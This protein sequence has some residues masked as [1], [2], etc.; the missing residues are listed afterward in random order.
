M[1]RERTTDASTPARAA[2]A[3]RLLALFDLSNVSPICV[4]RASWL[5]AASSATGKVVPPVEDETF[6]FD[7]SPTAAVFAPT[8]GRRAK[9][10]DARVARAPVKAAAVV[11]SQDAGRARTPGRETRRARDEG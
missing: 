3:S 1:A 10:D 11:K 6:P 8:R 2:D 4:S 9:D 7:A 5:R